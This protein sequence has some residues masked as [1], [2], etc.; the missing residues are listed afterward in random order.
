MPGHRLPRKP[1]AARPRTLIVA[2]SLMASILTGL[3]TPASAAPSGVIVDAGGLA[4]LALIPRS[5]GASA[6]PFTV[7]GTASNA[8][9]VVATVSADNQA[10]RI[11]RTTVGADGRFSLVGWIRVELVDHDVVIEAVDAQWARTPL[12]NYTRVVAGD[13]FVVQGQSNAVQAGGTAHSEFARTYGG[14]GQSV[15]LE[16]NRRWFVAASSGEGGAGG[17]GS[18]MAAVTVQETSVPMAIFNHANGGKPASFF[19][20]DDANP[21]NLDTNYGRMLTRLNEARVT[22]SVRATIYYQGEN[23]QHQ[24]EQHAALVPELIADWNDDFTMMDHTYVIQIREGCGVPPDFAVREI[25][26][27]FGERFE[28]VTTVSVNHV[29]GFDGCHYNPA[30]YAQI[31]DE[32]SD[33]LLRDYYHRGGLVGIDSPLP[34]F[35]RV[36]ANDN[37]LELYFANQTDQVSGGAASQFVLSPGGSPATA[38]A[39]PG[40]LT[41]SFANTITVGSTLSNISDQVGLWF[42][43]AGRS[44][45]AVDGLT[46]A[47]PGTTVPGLGPDVTRPS[48]ASQMRLTETGP[49]QVSIDWMAATDDVAVD[50]YDLYRSENGGGFSLLDSTQGLSLVDNG[51]VAGGSYSY[52]LRAVDAAG[53]AGWR[54]GIQTITLAGLNVDTERPSTPTGLRVVVNGDQ[55]TLVW[56]AS[57][58]NVGVTGYVIYN[59]T[60]NAEIQTTGDATTTTINGLPPGQHQFFVKAFDA[61]GNTSWRTNT[62]LAAIL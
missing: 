46:V 59:A 5:P 62:V 43:P 13:V 41:L 50:H 47:A 23:D 9:S 19:Q 33:L 22:A 32:L 16:T 2:L 53:N 18:H 51:A 24:P 49:G 38:T 56:G 26:R 48:R 12:A 37:T 40:K 28:D 31:G 20:R 10:N 1:A 60:D 30:G 45:L 6:A 58:D 4:D 25:Q 54:N 15:T 14:L 17:F 36:G 52:Y 55:A 42:S 39:S 11:F 29:A 21:F 27:S 35:A 44:M 7:T 3:A 8:V 57:T 61:A 34:Y